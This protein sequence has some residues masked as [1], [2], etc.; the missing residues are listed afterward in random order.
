MTRLFGKYIGLLLFNIL[1]TIPG[2]TQTT[3]DKKDY[4]SKSKDVYFKCTIDLPG[5]LQDS[6][7]DGK[8]RVK[9]GKATVASG[10]FKLE[11]L[12]TE[13]DRTFI[14]RIAHADSIDWSGEGLSWEVKCDIYDA[15]LKDTCSGYGWN[16][17]TFNIPAAGVGFDVIVKDAE[18][19]IL[20]A[21]FYAT[22]SEL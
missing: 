15:Q 8:Y 17:S 14:T 9:C 22:Q 18:T 12:V 1:I 20:N 16:M 11:G 5:K 4:T 19:M 3:A 13:K 10:T 2:L 21:K 7:V 6:V